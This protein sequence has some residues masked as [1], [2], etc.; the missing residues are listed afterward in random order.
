[1]AEYTIIDIL[2]ASLFQEIH[3]K[4]VL[5]CLYTILPKK[6]ALNQFFLFENDLASMLNI[7]IHKTLL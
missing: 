3:L 5:L 1:M 2:Q 7:Y 4:S 6:V